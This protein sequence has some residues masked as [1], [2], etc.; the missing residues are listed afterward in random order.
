MGYVTIKDLK[1]AKISSVN[2]LYLII[3]KVN[4]YFEGINKNKF[5]TL[6]PTNESQEKIKN[7]KN[8]R[9]KSEI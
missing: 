1:Y 7:M 2:P 4:K 6:G 5:L 8:C 9:V 3:N